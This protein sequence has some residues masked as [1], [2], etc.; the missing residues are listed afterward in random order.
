MKLKTNKSA[1]KRIVKIT[2]TGK[3]IS[4][5]LSAQHLVAGKSKRTR[6]AT[7]KKFVLKKADSKNIKKL[8]PYE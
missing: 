5:R 2:K 3:V 1:K 6:R 4:R 7:G 8:V